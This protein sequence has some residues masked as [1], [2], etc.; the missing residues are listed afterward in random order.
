MIRVII[1]IEFAVDRSEHVA[2]PCMDWAALCQPAGVILR[3]WASLIASISVPKKLFL[4]PKLY[5]T[6]LSIDWNRPFFFCDFIHRILYGVKSKWWSLSATKKRVYFSGGSKLE[7]T[8]RER[9]F[10][11]DPG[12]DCIPVAFNRLCDSIP[13]SASCVGW[14][15][16]VHSPRNPGNRK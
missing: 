12:T 7:Q 10:L 13:P 1:F 15:T 16:N 11:D 2:L 6:S 5:Q 4:S 3:S 8:R 14:M 9:M